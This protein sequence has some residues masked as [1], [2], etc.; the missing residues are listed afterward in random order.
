MECVGL[1][2]WGDDLRL[3]YLGILHADK[4]LQVGHRKLSGQCQLSLGK[5]LRKLSCHSVAMSTLP[6]MRRDPHYHPVEETISSLSY[7][8]SPTHSPRCL[9]A[10]C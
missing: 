6:R 1:V 3:E 7:Q 10:H 9:L 5:V 8:K 4:G 2:S